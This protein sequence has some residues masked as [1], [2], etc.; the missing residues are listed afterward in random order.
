MITPPTAIRTKG[1]GRR[2]AAR[3]SALWKTVHIRIPSRLTRTAR[4]RYRQEVCSVI[5][6]AWVRKKVSAWTPSAR[7]IRL[8]VKEAR[9][10]GSSAGEKNVPTEANSIQNSVAVSGVP[11]SPANTELIPAVTRIFRLDSFRWHHF[12]RKDAADPPNC[13]A[14]PSR[15]PE[16]PNKWVM[17]V[18][19]K[20]PGATRGLTGCPSR[21]AS[22]I[23]LV[24]LFPRS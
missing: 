3:C 24:P 18:A 17:A 5:V 6:N 1:L 9:K 12:A 10:Q 14:A 22:M 8:A 15:P 21:D 19:A 23:S 13:S 2:C 7:E 11:K 20:I 16:P 4:I